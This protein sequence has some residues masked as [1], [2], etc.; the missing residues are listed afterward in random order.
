MS[1]LREIPEEMQLVSTHL[2]SIE[3]ARL[4]MVKGVLRFVD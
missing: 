1:D 4:M 3:P 2:L